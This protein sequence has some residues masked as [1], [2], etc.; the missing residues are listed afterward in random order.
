[1]ENRHP[2]Y[3][4]KKILFFAALITLVVF[5]VL[6]EYSSKM[7]LKATYQIQIDRI[8]N[9]FKQNNIPT[10]SLE[11]HELYHRGDISDNAADLFEKVFKIR[12]EQEEV[13]HP[14]VPK[15]ED[16]YYIDELPP[17]QQ[18]MDSEKEKKLDEYLE[19]CA[20]AILI[21]KQAGDKKECRFPID[22]TKGTS[23]LLPQIS[24]I[25]DSVKL[26]CLYAYRQKQKGNIQE[27]MQAIVLS[28][29]LAQYLRQEPALI[30]QM[31]RHTSEKTALTMMAK[32]LSG[33]P[34]PKEY[35]QPIYSMIQ[36]ESKD[37]FSIQGCHAGEISM[38]MHLFEVYKDCDEMN[39]FSL[40]SKMSK[41][42]HFFY[43]LSS[44]WEQDQLEY[45]TMSYD[46]YEALLKSH[47]SHSWK[48]YLKTINRIDASGKSLP[49]LKPIT[50]LFLPGG[51]LKYNLENI[52]L[53]RCAQ[54]ILAIN[55]HCQ[56]H[57][58][59]PEKIEIPIDPF[60]DNPLRYKR[61]NSGFLVYSIGKD[62]EDN[63][64]DPVNDLV[65]EVQ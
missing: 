5:L 1:M 29:K 41:W 15:G 60:D 58:N 65:L 11:L 13:L 16:D 61:L 57:K 47:A 31:V 14:V 34:V 27:A 2:W 25:K 39:K 45:L 38:V 21:L 4:N 51:C 28:I 43:M 7:R 8:L 46:I 9:K 30:S 33:T 24:G 52:A 50:R 44:Y 26:L 48:L 54:A 12:D 59:F 40:G 22:W 35:I 62:E 37:F 63:Q 55:M 17:V 23:T 36:D 53:R 64:G 3:F 20:Q 49:I 42:Q 56:I 19:S 10:S 6:F 18:A 32:L